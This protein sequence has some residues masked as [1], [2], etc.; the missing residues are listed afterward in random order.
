[1]LKWAFSPLSENIFRFGMTKCKVV[2]LFSGKRKSGKDH[3][4]ELLAS[5]LGEQATIIRLVEKIWRNSYS[6]IAFEPSWWPS[7]PGRWPPNQS[8]DLLW[9]YGIIKLWNYKI[10]G[11]CHWVKDK[12]NATETVQVNFTLLKSDFFT[13]LFRLSGP[14]KECYAKE[15]G[16]DFEQM[17]SSGKPFFP[18]WLNLVYAIH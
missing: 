12:M 15:K 10:M 2:L 1:M 11:L 17:L 6:C 16:L 18:V 3:I 7:R 4:T 5:R 9:K 8:D 14:L 13:F